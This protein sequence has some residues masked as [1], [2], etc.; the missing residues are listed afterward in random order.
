MQVQGGGK[1]KQKTAAA[2]RFG[3]CS[4][5][6]GTTN[7]LLTPGFTHYNSFNLF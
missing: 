1:N 2:E 3:V 7:D 6:S 4:G 5:A